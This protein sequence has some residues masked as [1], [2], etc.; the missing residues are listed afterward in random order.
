MEKGIKSVFTKNLFNSLGDDF[1]SGINIRIKE[2]R[3]FYGL[4]QTDIAKVLNI[5][6]QQYARYEIVGYNINRTDSL[7]LAIFYNV[8]LDFLYGFRDDPKQLVENLRR[9]THVNGYHLSEMRKK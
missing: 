3:K 1:D 8:S 7:L 9:E 2:L 4:T 6:Q 5:S